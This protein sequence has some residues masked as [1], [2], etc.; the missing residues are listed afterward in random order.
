[1]KCN[2][3][4]HTVPGVGYIF[5]FNSLTNNCECKRC[6]ETWLLWIGGNFEGLWGQLCCSGNTSLD[7]NQESGALFLPKMCDHKEVIWLLW[8]SLSSLMKWVLTPALKFYMMM[9]W[10]L[11]TLNKVTTTFLHIKVSPLF[12]IG[13]EASPLQ[14]NW[15]CWQPCIAAIVWKAWAKEMTTRESSQTVGKALK[16]D[17]IMANNN[18]A[19]QLC[20]FRS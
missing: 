16:E 12:L 6:V 19:L 1:M 14:W 5:K 3:N 8:D 18:H 10:L 9:F 15:P 13:M 17:V 7:F 11:A 20:L 2:T 4:F